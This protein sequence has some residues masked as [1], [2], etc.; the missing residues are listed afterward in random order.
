MSNAADTHD[1]SATCENCTTPLQ[2][3]YCHQCG[4]TAHNPLRHVGHAIE[5]VFESFWHLDGRIFRTLRE[6]WAPGRLANRYLAGHRAPYI[7]PLRLFV[8]VSVI[9]FFLAQFAVSF[10]EPG[11]TSPSGARVQVNQQNVFAD[12]RTVQD[13]ITERDDSIQG[14][15]D[16]KEAVKGIPGVSAGFD[17]SIQTMRE[18][19]RARIA[20]LDPE[21]P[22][23]RKP[24]DQTGPQQARA[25]PAEASGAATKTTGDRTAASVPAN[26]SQASAEQGF[27]AR[28]M[29]KKSKRAEANWRS[30][31]EDP[32]QLK[33]AIMGSIPTALFFLVPIFAIF[34]KL[35]YVETGRG[36]LEHLVVALYSHAWLCLA[37][38]VLCV[39]AML[40]AWI[41]PHARWFGM[42]MG[43]LEF[44]TWWWMPIYLLLMQKRVYRQAWWLT[45]LKYLVIG[46]VY[47]VLV[48][49]AAAFVAISSFISG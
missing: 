39:F 2:G 43:V 9:T 3:H 18:Q 25:L 26:A 45:V 46:T 36:Y 24:L 35:A 47:M 30:F 11:S 37:L 42:V 27:I 17:R 14:L 44:L 1:G 15:L 4:Q 23:L 22:E 34:L 5:E 38:I 40:D 33:H 12:A 49:F 32:E 8:V 41:T 7:A 29:E 31:Q 6:I 16:G 19:A 48:G 28:W 10:D 21:H 20:E 13:V